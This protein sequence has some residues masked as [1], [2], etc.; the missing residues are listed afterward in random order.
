MESYTLGAIVVLV[1]IILVALARRQMTTAPKSAPFYITSAANGH[2][3]QWKTGHWTLMPNMKAGGMA[4]LDPA[5][6]L[7]DHT[8]GHM[9]KVPPPGNAGNNQVGKGVHGWIP[10]HRDSMGRLL[11]GSTG[12]A[13]AGN[14][15]KPILYG[16][17]VADN[18]WI[19]IPA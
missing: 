17:G 7:L 19:F 5:G 10:L 3:L 18:R 4:V 12:N 2:A 16:T 6:M 15:T 8:S 13:L 9:L 14:A 11:A 1:V